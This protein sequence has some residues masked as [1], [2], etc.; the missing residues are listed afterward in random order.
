MIRPGCCHCDRTP[1][2]VRGSVIFPEDP[3]AR[4]L[5]VYA[6]RPCGAHV[7]TARNPS[8]TYRPLGRP[9][10]PE[11]HNA[12]R[13]CHA[14]IDPIWQQAPSSPEYNAHG[15]EALPIIR[16]AKSRVFLY[17]SEIL[18]VEKREAH[19]EWLDVDQCRR[20]YAAMRGVTYSEIRQWFKEREKKS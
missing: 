17:L 7:G 5:Y 11:V 20:A 3:E 4:D 12:R 8:G 10:N 18:R 9:G 15:R 1:R 13:H 19:I 16:S 6:C 2:L 14:L